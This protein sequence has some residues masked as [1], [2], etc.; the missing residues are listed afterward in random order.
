[1]ISHF[2]QFLR[3]IEILEV[4]VVLGVFKRLACDRNVQI[5]M[6]TATGSFDILKYMQKTVLIQ[7]LMMLKSVS[8]NTGGFRPIP[9][10][11]RSKLI[12]N[13]MLR[14][15]FVTFLYLGRTLA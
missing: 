14:R 3:S 5:L 1:M 10:K 11:M 4:M 7:L 15:I 13:D 6:L 12:S 2:D 8:F 9:V